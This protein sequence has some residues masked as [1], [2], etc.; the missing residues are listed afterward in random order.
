MRLLLRN[1]VPLFLA[2]GL[3]SSLAV[4]GCQS[5]QQAAPQPQQEAQP[6]PQ[7]E[8]QPST[9]LEWERETHRQ[10]VDMNK[11]SAE[12]QR[13]YQEWLRTHNPRH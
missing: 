10:H 7:P 4:A 3:A 8:P 12:E 9:Y 13:Q 6:A 5:Q 2:A 1:L 11:R